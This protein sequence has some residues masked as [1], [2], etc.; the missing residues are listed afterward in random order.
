MSRRFATAAVARRRDGRISGDNFL[1]LP[2]WERAPPYS[3][4]PTVPERMARLKIA[5]IRAL[6]IYA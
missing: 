5:H 6:A 4:S 2:L 3:A 1:D